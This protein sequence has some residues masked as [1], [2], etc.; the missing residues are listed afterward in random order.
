MCE[1]IKNTY[2]EWINSFNSDIK[3][4][5]IINDIQQLCDGVLLTYILNFIMP[6]IFEI[7]LLP[8]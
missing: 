4:F 6:N 7:K 3:N 8:K 5:I 2:I 1:N